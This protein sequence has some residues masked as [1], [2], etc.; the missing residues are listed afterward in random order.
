VGIGCG[1]NSSEPIDAPAKMP[2]APSGSCPT[3]ELCLDVTKSPYT[4]LA[5]TNGFAVVSSSKGQ[6]I[7]VRTSP[8]AVAA[9][10][11]VCTHQGCTV[12]YRSSQTNLYCPC[13]GAQY[14][15]TGAVQVGPASVPLKMYAATLSG[16]IITITLA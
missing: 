1:G 16:N 13:H 6:L 4:G 2:D 5:N 8:T 10:S 11:A 12:T 7:V 14:S 15:L 3:N 9:L